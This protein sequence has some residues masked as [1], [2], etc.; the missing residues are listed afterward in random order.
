[1]PGQPFVRQPNYLQL[2]PPNQAWADST[3]SFITQH[4]AV[5]A[6]RQVIVYH[7]AAP[8]D[9]YT[10]SFAQDVL[11]AAQD[12]PVTAGPAPE[13][14][15]GP[16]QIPRSVCRDAGAVPAALFFADRWTTFRA[17]AATLT[18][19]CGS[20][21]PGMLIATDNVDRFMTN[22]TAR[23]SVTA[24]WPMAYFRK[25]QQRSDLQTAAADPRSPSAELL[26]SVRSVLASC[27]STSAG[28]PTQIGDRVPMF[29]DAV[30][31]AARTL[32][33]SPVLGHC[34][35]RH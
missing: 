18:A 10:Q 29:W 1:M 2:S 7:V 24:P 32:R 33:S 30:S 12:D 25:G 28:T 4:T 26:A 20:H 16:G 5:G 19:L 31:L 22:D 15:T 6:H 35:T 9:E 14:V 3:V 21:G 27:T 23:A 11:S 17:F 13:M 34:L 8:G